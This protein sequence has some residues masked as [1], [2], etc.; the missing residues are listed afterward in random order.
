MSTKLAIVID[1]NQL[2][3]LMREFSAEVDPDNE[4]L[5]QWTFEIFLQWLRKRQEQLSPHIMDTQ[6]TP[7]LK[8][9]IGDIPIM[10]LNDGKRRG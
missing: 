2:R 4:D 3:D 7:T 8:E 9:F 10:K 1:I 6:G 5:L